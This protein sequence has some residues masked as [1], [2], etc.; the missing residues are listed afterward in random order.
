MGLVNAA[1]VSRYTLY[2]VAPVDA[3]H[4]TKIEFDAVA[5]DEAPVG[6]T[7]RVVAV[8]VADSAEEP[9]LFDAVSS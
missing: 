6:M 7:G 4:V 9:V 2:T 3:V 1:V 5:I 8:T